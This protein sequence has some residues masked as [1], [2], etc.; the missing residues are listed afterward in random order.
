LTVDSFDPGALVPKLDAD[1]LD[2]LVTAAGRV[3][4]ARFG[5]TAERVTALAGVSKVQDNADW[6]SAA[7]GLES[8]TIVS[9]I[10]LFTLGERLPGWEAGARSPVIP[11]AAELKARDAYPDDL[12][13]WI[14]ANSD[15]R[16]L[17]YG[18]LLDRL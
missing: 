4:E 8:E 15:N 16:F 7:T 5:L 18:S 11:L 12:T 6:R 10:R 17:P 3:D 2:E 13:A 9:L 14:R 1:V